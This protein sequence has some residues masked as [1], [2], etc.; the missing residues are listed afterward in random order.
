MRKWICMSCLLA[1]MP[2]FGG[3]DAISGLLPNQVV[4]VRLVNN[5]TTFGIDVDIYIASEQLVTETVLTTSGTLLE[6][7]VA[8]GQTAT[9]SRDCDELQA[10]IVADADLQLLGIFETMSNVLRDGT[11]FSCGSTITF[12]FTHSALLIDFTVTPTVEN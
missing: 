10:I 9:F 3:C 6:F 12:T 5:S 11:D 2:S 8:A 4:T 7:L 1:V